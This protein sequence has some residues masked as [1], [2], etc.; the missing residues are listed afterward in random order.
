M[1]YFI[2]S[3]EIYGAE[4]ILYTGSASP[5]EEYL[6]LIV[7]DELIP[8]MGDGSLYGRG[9]Y[10]VYNLAGTITERGGYGN[11]IYKLKVNLYGFISFNP[12]I[13][14][15][16]Y[17]ES[18]TLS[19]QYETI[20]GKRGYIFEQLKEL[21]NRNL[22]DKW[23]EGPQFSSDLAKEASSFLKGKVKGILFSGR[24]DGD[25]AV[26]YD[27]LT[28]VP[29]A[30]KYIN[31]DDPTSTDTWHRFSQEEI[32]PAIGR[33]ML[34]SFEESKYEKATD[35]SLY[36]AVKFLSNFSGDNV[37]ERALKYIN[38]LI[39]NEPI[40]FISYYSERKWAQPYLD[41]VAKSLAK[42]NPA[43]LIE[44]YR[45]KAW[46][47]PHMDSAA[48]EIIKK[49][50]YHFISENFIYQSKR[51]PWAQKYLTM[52][53]DIIFKKAEHSAKLSKLAKAL[54]NVNLMAES[55]EIIGLIQ[56]EASYNKP[57]VGK[58]RWS[59]KQKRGVD[60]SNPK[61]FSQK[62]YCKRKAR[63]GGYK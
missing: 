32:K 61:G 36:N 43:L 2:K 25:V 33:G 53:E 51:D 39:D 18:L 45:D 41:S 30:W 38:Y 23:S 49:D 59:I 46:A 31:P 3:A 9:I 34:G 22:R 55:K 15:K 12:E 52:A 10:T 47:Q 58:K 50:P 40:R 35:G 62:Q 24:R 54:I 1:S 17:G 8:G 16:I 4:A 42:K 29:V 56:K 60:C 44:L 27:P 57:R 5:P 11:Y 63:G 20:S 19:Q 7:N 26:I 21:E 48:E 37:D 6:R 28:V 14:K 13:T